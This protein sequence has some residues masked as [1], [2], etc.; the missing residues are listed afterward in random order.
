MK[1][2]RLLNKPGLKYKPV[3]NQGQTRGPS[4]LEDPKSNE[5]AA[6]HKKSTAQAEKSGG[7]SLLCRILKLNLL[8][9]ILLL[10]LTEV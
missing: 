8:M 3:I 6:K 5:I 10:H 1:I 4:L 9:H 2:K 7:V